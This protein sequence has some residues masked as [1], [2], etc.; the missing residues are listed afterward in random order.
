MAANSKR[1]QIL[2][3]YKSKFE[4]ISS[5]KQVKRTQPSSL[6]ELQRFSSQQMP[7][8]CMI[9]GVPKPAAHVKGRGPGGKDLFLSE[10]TILNF[11]YFMDNS[12]PDSTLSSLLDDLWAAIMQ[13]QT[14][15]GLATEI[16]LS[17]DM[18]VAVWD[19]YMAFKFEIKVTYKH[20]TGGI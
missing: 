15:G 4:N 18:Q 7:L 2:L 14:L 1:E 10:L 16:D 8:L 12:N 17:P 20:G 11:V 13:D 6:N 5:I 3:Y 9:G 19:P